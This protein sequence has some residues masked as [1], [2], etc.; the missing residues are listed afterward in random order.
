MKEMIKK[1]AIEKP[2]LFAIVTIIIG[3]SSGVLLMVFLPKNIF[4]IVA[5]V[6][7]VLFPFLAR[8]LEKRKG[9]KENKN[10]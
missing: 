3:L 8:L 4:I 7:T 10:M 6:C 1:K 5:I 2:Y 9:N